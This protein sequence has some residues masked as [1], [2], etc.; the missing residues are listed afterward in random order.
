M[1]DNTTKTETETKKWKIYCANFLRLVHYFLIAYVIIVPWTY[2]RTLLRF[3]VQLVLFLL[4]KWLI[5]VECNMTHFEHKLRGIEKHEGFIYQFLQP[6]IDIRE[7]Q[8]NWL[9]YTTVIILGTISYAKLHKLE[10][11]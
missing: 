11:H 4:F 5:T 2:N 3:H 6:I 7:S 9:C 1:S 8:V 10:K